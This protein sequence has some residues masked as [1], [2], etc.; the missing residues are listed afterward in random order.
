[1][2]LKVPL[3]HISEASFL[4]YCTAVSSV[5]V[6]PVYFMKCKVDGRHFSPVSLIFH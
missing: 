1:M 2:M 3:M 5:S 4:H 6:V